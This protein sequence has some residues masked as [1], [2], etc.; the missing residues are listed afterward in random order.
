MYLQRSLRSTAYKHSNFELEVLTVFEYQSPDLALSPVF[1]DASG[2][3]TTA[4]GWGVA[5]VGGP[6]P[7]ENEEERMGISVLGCVVEIT[8]G[9]RGV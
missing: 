9:L 5:V 3:V 1:L 4:V 2:G 8:G 6:M 7:E